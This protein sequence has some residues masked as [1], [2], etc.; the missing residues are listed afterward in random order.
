MIDR[1]DSGDT[2]QIKGVCVGRF[3]IGKT[4][5]IMGKPT[6]ELARAVLRGNG[7][8][9]VMLIAARVRVVNLKITGGGAHSGGGIRVRK[10]GTLT[11]N[12]S[13]V[14]GN[15]ADGGGGIWNNGTL[16][17]YQSMVRGNSARVGG[18]IY[19]Q[20]GALH[21]GGIV[22]LNG[23][24]SVRGNMAHGEGGG[25]LVDGGGI[26]TL[27]D[28][29]SVRGNRASL[30]GGGIFNFGSLILNDLSFVTRNRADFKDRGSGSG[31][32]ILQCSTSLLTGA[33][34][35]GN[36]NDNYLGSEGRLENNIAIDA[37]G[38]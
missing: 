4:L 10:T 37:C 9:G 17:L 21:E 16:T 11:L 14:R 28:S 6:P 7:A 8:G 29:S 20:P 1:A 2:I 38:G 23:S 24:S 19:S 27:N 30:D 12:R 36:V 22:T 5:T 15:H 31:G 26:V 34:D 32:G 33:V 13:E 3:R 18:G 25:I 35:G